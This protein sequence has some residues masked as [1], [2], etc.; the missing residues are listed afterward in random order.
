MSHIFREL[1]C[2]QQCRIFV[3]VY[4]IRTRTVVKSVV[5]ASGVVHSLI[6]WPINYHCMFLLLTLSSDANFS[7][8]CTVNVPSLHILLPTSCTTLHTPHHTWYTRTS[9]CFIGLATDAS[10]HDRRQRQDR[11]AQHL[12]LGLSIMEQAALYLAVIINVTGR[13]A[14]DARIRRPLQIVALI[15]SVF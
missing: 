9:A 8:K 15:S 14:G 12:S 2:L 1:I 10:G 6:Q 5:V 13:Q 7:P 3:P 4:S 11:F